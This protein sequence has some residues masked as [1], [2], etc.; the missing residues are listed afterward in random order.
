MVAPL[1]SCIS[2]MREGEKN[3]QSDFSVLLGPNS[4][5]T[6]GIECFKFASNSFAF[7]CF[8]LDC[9]QMG[10]HKTMVTTVQ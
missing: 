3:Q 5:A 8:L 4:W 7:F 2:A 10:R 1:C 9:A 6:K